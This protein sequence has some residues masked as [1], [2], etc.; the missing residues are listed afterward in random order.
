MSD[1]GLGMLV[2]TEKPSLWERSTTASTARTDFR[3]ILAGELTRH[4]RRRTR[5]GRRRSSRPSRRASGSRASR[6]RSSSPS[7]SGSSR[8][9]CTTCR[10]RP[11]RPTAAT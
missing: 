11:C 3:A 9:R 1:V 5:V 6:P 2:V 4:R 7:S 10:T 8:R